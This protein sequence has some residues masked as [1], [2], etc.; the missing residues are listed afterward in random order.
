MAKGW[1]RSHPAEL[2]PSNWS[3]TKD[4]EVAAT[5]P[6]AERSPSLA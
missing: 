5:G 2:L 6:S 4:I 1:P 3:A